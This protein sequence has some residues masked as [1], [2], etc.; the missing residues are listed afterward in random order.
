MPYETL[1]NYYLNASALLIPLRPNI[2]D[3]ARFPQKISEYVISGNPIITTKY[4][5]VIN[6]FEDSVN[7]LIADEYDVN[8]F[9]KKMEYIIK[10]PEKSLEIGLGGKEVGMKYFNYK[11]YSS[12]LYNLL[13]NF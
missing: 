11:N 13:V 4:G 8:L 5:E 10:Y 9:S 6:Y 7:A 12:S 3:K 2:Q 1:L